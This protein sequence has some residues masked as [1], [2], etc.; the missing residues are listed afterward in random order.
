MP[1]F[2]NVDGVLFELLLFTPPRDSVGGCTGLQPIGTASDG[3]STSG[4]PIPLKRTCTEKAASCRSERN[5]GFCGGETYPGGSEAKGKNVAIGGCL[6]GDRSTD[7]RSCIFLGAVA[8]LLS[9]VVGAWREMESPLFDSA[10]GVA[11]T[12]KLA[13]RALGGEVSRT[14]EA[15]ATAVRESLARVGGAEGVKIAAHQGTESG[16]TATSGLARSVTGGVSPMSRIATPRGG[17]RDSRGASAP[18]SPHCDRSRGRCRGSRGPAPI[19]PTQ[20]LGFSGCTAVAM[21]GGHFDSATEDEMAPRA[22]IIHRGVRLPFRWFRSGTARGMD[23]ALREVLGEMHNETEWS[24][25]LDTH[26]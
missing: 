14:Q 10:G 3:G 24:L 5:A 17:W 2:P 6:G 11:G 25:C 16:G 4:T 22:T 13:A 26:L 7:S 1:I 19:E 20:Q 21:E 18:A 15:E 9:E 23:E 8:L 12:I